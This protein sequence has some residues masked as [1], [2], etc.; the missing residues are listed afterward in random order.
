MEYIK[1]LA[2]DSTNTELKKR[3]RRNKSMQNTCL[4]ATHQT[5]GKGQRGTRWHAKAGNNLTY[6]VLLKDLNL[7]IQ[8]NFKISAATSLAL[9]SVLQIILKD[10][11][12]NI[13]WPNDILAGEKKICGILIENILKGKNIHHCIIGIGLN[14]NQ[15]DFTQLPKASSLKKLTG[16]TF[17]LDQLLTQCT[18]RVAKEVYLSLDTPINGL[19]NS[20][21]AYLFKKDKKATFKVPNGKKRKGII[22]GITNSGQLKVRFDTNMEHFRTKEI[23]LVY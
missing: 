17:N 10:N 15:T 22:C 3:F 13:K 14:I 5:K 12:I 8:D 21:E 23:Q 11:T 7:S 6:S 2:T 4:S 1:V 18:E 19:L 20:Y 16:K 9:V